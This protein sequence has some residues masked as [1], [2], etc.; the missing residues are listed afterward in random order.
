MD[1]NGIPRERLA[2]S[3]VC[4]GNTS[5]CAS[6]AILMPF[7]AHR[8]L[9][10][11]PVEIDESWGLMTIRKG[12]AY[13]IC[14]SLLCGVCGLL[15]LDI[16]FSERELDA[17]Y[18]DYRGADYVALRERYEPGYA[19]RN[20]TFDAGIRY[21]DDVEAFLS[22]HLPASP[23]VL[24]WGGDTGRNTPFAGRRAL[25]HVY[26]ISN[27]AVLAG[28]ANVDRATAFA[29]AYDLVVCSNVLEHVPYP[30][31]LIAELRG[32][33]TRDTILY[34]EVPHEEVVRTHRG[35]EA[36][37]LKKRHWHEHI[38]FFSRESLLRL[39]ANSGLAVVADHELHI[40]AEGR[41]VALFQL[42]CR[43]AP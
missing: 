13:S 3:C 19:L 39:L 42:A 23:N 21:L 35:P 7:V 12:M 20:Q 27:K 9:G 43:L 18:A 25:C 36:L 38:N 1:M 2:R 10:W 17:L 33:M 6:P 4:C 31:E 28:V 16:R 29:T 34:I 8:A 14:N 41:P 26:D 30:S 22:P 32:T 37:N 11:Q 5:L 40:V 24:D 15:F